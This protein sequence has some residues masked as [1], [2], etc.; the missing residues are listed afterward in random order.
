MN[1]PLVISVLSAHLGYN[2]L[3]SYMG[4][5]GGGG[6]GGL[7][8]FVEYC[9]IFKVRLF[10]VMNALLVISI[11][12]TS[13]VVCKHKIFRDVLLNNTLDY[14]WQ[15]MNRKFVSVTLCPSTSPIPDHILTK[16]GQWSSEQLLKI[17]G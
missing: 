13:C 16:P 6:G 15:L 14:M 9:P 1:A 17:L 11:L 4:G 10:I 12:K 7:E 8:V 3:L 5:G 2:S